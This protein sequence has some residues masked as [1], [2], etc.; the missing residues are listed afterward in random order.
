MLV[1]LLPSPQYISETNTYL[2]SEPNLVTFTVIT[3]AYK[4]VNLSGN[5]E[6]GWKDPFVQA[7]ATL[8]FCF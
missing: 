8:P 5:F 6:N 3:A 4:I 2:Y 7:M 1:L